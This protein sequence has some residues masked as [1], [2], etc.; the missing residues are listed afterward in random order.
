MITSATGLILWIYVPINEG[1]MFPLL[2]AILP[3]TI[4]TM[5]KGLLK[6][7][8]LTTL[9]LSAFYM[10][11]F[12]FIMPYFTELWQLVAFYFINIFALWKI[13]SAPQRALYKVLGGNYLVM[14]TMGALH[15]TPTYTIDTSLN[16]LIQLFV[17]LGI[18]YFFEKAASSSH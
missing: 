17:I 16:M 2:A 10:L 1:I 15:L 14:F 8:V 18:I 6:H 11:Q 13:C 5:P 4:I 12:I 3:I 9:I 7:V